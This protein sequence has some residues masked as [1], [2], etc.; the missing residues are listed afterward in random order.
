MLV[1]GVETSCDETAAA[2][3]E[4]GRRVR[5]DVVASQIL[6]HA[7]YGGVVPEVASRQH[8][9]TI[10]P[11]LRRAVADAGIGFPDLDGIAVTCGPGL[12]G[13][14]L[15]GVETAKALAY[16]LGKPLVGVNHLAGHLAAVFL[17]DPAPFS[18]AGPPPFPHLAL[19][20]SGGHTALIRVDG[21]GE[22]RLL[23]STRDD[24][25]GEAFDKVGKMLGLGYP[26]GVVVDKLAA[27]G[28]P[29]AHALPR[30]LPGRDDLDFSFSGLKT[31]VSTLLGGAARVLPKAAGGGDSHLNAGRAGRPAAPEGAAL[32]DLCASFQAAVVDVLV[33]KSRRALVREGLGDLIV[34]GGVAANRGLRDGLAAAAAEDGFRLYIPPPKRCTDNASM[35]AAAGTQLLARG[36]RAPLDLS[37]DPGLPL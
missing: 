11:V 29:R 15:V 5:A 23:G 33:R 2:V 24:A 35:I 21:P 27:T 14:L 10:V 19:L 31:A 30:A 8:V 37:V 16:A 4:D 26:G 9:A 28:D 1:L 34:C 6:V 25:A 20:V 7:E 18:A 3:V 32:A 22:T 36:M 12:V 17:E 13:A